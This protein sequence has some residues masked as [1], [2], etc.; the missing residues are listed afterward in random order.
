MSVGNHF[1]TRGIFLCSSSRFLEGLVAR[2][3]LLVAEAFD[4]LADA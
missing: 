3:D 2:K 1:V 4:S